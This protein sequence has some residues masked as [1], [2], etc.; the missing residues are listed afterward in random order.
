MSEKRVLIAGR[1]RVVLTKAE[2]ALSELPLSLELE[3]NIKDAGK[4]MEEN[5]PD[6]VVL[7]VAEEEDISLLPLFFKSSPRP[8]VIILAPEDRFPLIANALKMG[9]DDYLTK[10]F[11]PK[12]LALRVELFLKE[13]LIRDKGGSSFIGGTLSELSVAELIKGC[14]DNFLTGELLINE[15]NDKFV[16]RFEGGRVKEVKAGGKR[17]EE[18]IEKLLKLTEGKF[19]IIQYPFNLAKREIKE[20]EG[21]KK[22]PSS[23]LEAG[24][25]GSSLGRLSSIEISGKNYQIQTELYTTGEGRITTLVISEGQIYKKIEKA[26]PQAEESELPERIEKVNQ[27][28]QQVMETLNEVVPLLLANRD[29]VAPLLMQAIQLIETRLK[30]EVGDFIT[31]YYLRKTKEKLSATYPFL[32]K[33]TINEREKTR[34]SR[35]ILKEDRGRLIEGIARWLSSTFSQ[36]KDQ[37]PRLKRGGFRELTGPLEYRLDWI[38]FFDR[39]NP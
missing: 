24:M 14:E 7:D 9:A 8:A 6:I 12:D 11:R 21:E 33:I 34:L 25:S 19:V 29:I 5:P 22:P 4:R 3:Q 2:S 1:E 37:S 28:H 23:A 31:L 10:P 16:I 27:Q 32:E 30:E 18:A 20:E 15:G 39:V 26:W 38:G 35:D 17:E 36:V 13:E